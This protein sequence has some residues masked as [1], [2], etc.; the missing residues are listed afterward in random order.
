[1]NKRN[2]HFRRRFT[3]LLLSCAL[4]I[5]F[6]SQGFDMFG[7]FKKQEVFLSSKIE[8]VVTENGKPVVNL[9]ITRSLLYSDGKDHIDI[10]ITDNTGHFYFPQKSTRSSLASKPFVEDR[11]SQHITI[12]RDGV[13]I[14]LWM[15]TSYGSKE[16]PEYTKKLAFL[17]CELTNEIV[18]F[19]FRN[20]NPDNIN[21]QAASICRWDVDYIPVWIMGDDGESK[22]RIHDGDFNKLTERFTGKEVKL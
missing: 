15:A 13:T 3:L 1:M 16:T 4:A 19:E 11:V 2:S 7:W 22:Y 20:R 14:P 9:E 21:H 6:I 8:G 18:S 17:N 5:P 10:A 12:E